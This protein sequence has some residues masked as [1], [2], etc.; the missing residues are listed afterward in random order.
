MIVIGI[1]FLVV[2]CVLLGIKNQGSISHA[3]IIL[4]LVCGVLLLMGGALQS[5]V[6]VLK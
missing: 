6:E 4:C 1:C 2:A 5:L 3:A